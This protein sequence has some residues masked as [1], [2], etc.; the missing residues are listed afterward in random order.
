M[1]TKR[2]WLWGL[3]FLVAAVAVVLKGFGWMVDIP[4]GQA[5]WTV[6]VVLIG[7]EAVRKR[8]VGGIL[9]TL[10][11]LAIIWD[12]EL[13]IEAIT[14]WPILAA[15][16][17]AAIG[18]RL[19]FPRKDRYVINVDGEEKCYESWSDMKEG[20][21]E[22]FCSDEQSADGSSFNSESIF[23]GG[24]KYI[25]SQDFRTGNLEVVF[26]TQKLYF[27]NAQLHNGK[28]NLHVSV[29]F[30]TLEVYV[31][32]GW[33]VITDVEKVFS[34]IKSFETPGIDGPVLYIDGEVV[35]GNLKI[36]YI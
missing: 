10:A 15:A 35:F 16:T 11:F 13:G 3:L 4:W 9:Y 31:P 1:K 7:V 5:I 8:S 20:A 2:N 6:V 28:G 18:I 24:T 12:A 36:F 14:P 29:V 19:I 26:G 27:D 17:L 33:K 32:R 21:R 34:G 23:S 30:S 22:E 25:D